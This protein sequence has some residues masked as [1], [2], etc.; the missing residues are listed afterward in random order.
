MQPFCATPDK[1]GMALSEHSILVISVWEYLGFENL[2][3]P[4]PDRR[5]ALEWDDDRCQ[6]ETMIKWDTGGKG[7]PEEARFAHPIASRD[8]RQNA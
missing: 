3:I 7:E 4:Q 8:R 6:I 5:L 2:P 1:Q